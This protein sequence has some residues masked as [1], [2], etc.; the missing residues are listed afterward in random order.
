MIGRDWFLKPGKKVGVSLNWWQH[1]HYKLEE[2][3]LDLQKSCKCL[4]AA[5]ICNLGTGKSLECAKKCIPSSTRE[6]VSK[7]RRIR[8]RRRSSS[9]QLKETPS[10]ELWPYKYLHVYAHTYMWEMINLTSCNQ[11]S[12]CEVT[13][14]RGRQK[15][16]A[17]PDSHSQLTLP[18]GQG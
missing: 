4:V 12:V 10:V 2:L 14:K 3:S 9:E 5:Q 11:R 7:K 17:L 15:Y 16:L 6:L 1:L 13:L 18:S 8:R